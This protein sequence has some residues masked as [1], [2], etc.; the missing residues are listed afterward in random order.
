VIHFETLRIALSSLRAHP[1]RT[2]L[3]LLGVIIGVTTVVTVVSIISG[4]NAYIEDKVLT[5]GADAF[6]VS[7]FGIITSRTGFIEALKRRDMSLEDMDALERL[8]SE[9]VYVGGDI[10]A[11]KG[12]RYEDQRLADT[13][14]HGATANIN[15]VQSLEIEE[16][17]FFSDAEVEA[18]RP[19]AVI[20]YDVKEEL[21]QGVDP[22]G[23]IIK[24]DG[25]PYKV[26]GLLQK[27]GSILGQ[28]QDKVV[29][30]PLTTWQKNFG[31]HRSVEVVVKARGKERLE[32]AQEQ[33]RLIL[34]ARRHTLYGDPDPFG[35]VTSSALD[36]I[37]KGIT[38]GAFALMT[39]I[40]AIS[41]VVGGIVIMNI[42]LVSV[43]ERTQE[44]GVRRAMGA[45][46]RTIQIQ[47]LMEAVLMAAG[48]GAIGVAAGA[49]VAQLVERLSPL[50][51]A[52][53][54]S[55]VVASILLA[56]LVGVVSGV[57]PSI[58]AAR[59]QPVDALRSE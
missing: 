57:F 30:V 45:R 33:V 34:R 23:R 39:F 38:A 47:F 11:N 43:A 7:K 5:L 24:V 53:R 48:G 1:L 21:I 31:A 4:L 51:V 25:Y 35:F 22:I 29:Y 42:M 49:G 26:V 59:L 2:F 50:P 10:A 6:V 46:R 19:V 40:S 55:L 13:S 41:L 12:V 52:V 8:C 20:G 32:A 37:W 56:T 18:A 36:Q 17:R 28:N 15:E 44:I 27:K 9:C 54:P 14:V 3:T 16:G 58:K